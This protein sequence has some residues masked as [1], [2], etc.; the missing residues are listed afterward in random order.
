ME[1]LS[2]KTKKQ[3]VLSRIIYDYIINGLSDSLSSLSEEDV[4]L[5]IMRVNMQAMTHAIDISQEDE[6]T[7]FDYCF[8]QLGLSFNTLVPLSQVEFTSVFI[9]NHID[10]IRTE[11]GNDFEDMVTYLK[12]MQTAVA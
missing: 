2:L 10:V 9:D 5:F 4:Q 12:K 1:I 8:D 11:L 3:I 6:I 7:D